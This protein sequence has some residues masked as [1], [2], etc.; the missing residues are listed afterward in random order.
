MSYWYRGSLFFS[1]GVVGFLLGVVSNQLYSTMVYNQV[2]NELELYLTQY[3]H[4]ITMQQESM[5][6]SVTAKLEELSTKQ[7][8]LLEEELVEVAVTQ[9]L[10]IDNRTIYVVEEYDSVSGEITENIDALPAKYIG[11]DRELLEAEL[12]LYTTAPN[13]LDQQKGFVSASLV[14]FSPEKIVIRKTYY[15]ELEV[16]IPDYYYLRM[17]EGSVI[18]YEHDLQTIYMRTDISFESLPTDIQEE[19]VQIKKLESEAELYNFLEAYSS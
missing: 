18:V 6:Q 14:S 11:L 17:E 19:I 7:V 9:D 8:A 2:Q 15:V 16:E 10:K 3:T 5:I 12:A 1:I 4:G 13:L